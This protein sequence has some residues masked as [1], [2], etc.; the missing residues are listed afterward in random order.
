MPELRLPRN[1]IELAAIHD[2]RDAVLFEGRGRSNYDR[3]HPD[4]LSLANHFMGFWQDSE[5]IGT[6]RVDFLDSE[7]AALRLVAVAPRL[8]RSGIGR[9]MIAAAERFIVMA[10]CSRVVTNAAVDAVEF[11]S[12]LGYEEAPWEDPGEGAAE[13]TVPMQ[14]RLSP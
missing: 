2:L 10:G 6:L 13:R 8:Q 4:D 12:R 14:K 7:T 9:K 11:Y 5:L 1:D 3:H